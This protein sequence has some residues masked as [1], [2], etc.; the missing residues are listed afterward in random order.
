M[1]ERIGRIEA[2]LGEKQPTLALYESA[3]KRL[4]AKKT[5]QLKKELFRLAFGYWDELPA[6][7]RKFFT[8]LYI[9]DREM[10]LEQVLLHTPLGKLRYKLHKPELLIKL[11]HILESGGKDRI[12]SYR[13]LA[14]SLLLG[15]EF[16]FTPGT[17][18]AYLRKPPK[19]IQPGE[20]LQM[21]GRI[22]VED[23][24]L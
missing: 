3:V 23:D 10:L 13:H 1:H 2:V 6:C 12:V 7:Y 22:E 24:W 5:E 18:N 15:F 4:P 20:L 17:L 19:L 8:R 11:L 9:R 16:R 14:I 21:M